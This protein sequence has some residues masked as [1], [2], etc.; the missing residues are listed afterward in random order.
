MDFFSTA[1]WVHDPTTLTQ[2]LY[3]NKAPLGVFHVT[4][5]IPNCVNAT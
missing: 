5:Y 4:F 3:H 1:I 2:N